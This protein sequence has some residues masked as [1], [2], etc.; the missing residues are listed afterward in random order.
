VVPWFRKTAVGLAPF[1]QFFSATFGAGVA[2]RRY[3][4][5]DIPLAMPFK[6]VDVMDVK[7]EFV[8]KT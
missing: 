1:V 8:L 3:D 6:G 7:K 2:Y 5:S 4:V